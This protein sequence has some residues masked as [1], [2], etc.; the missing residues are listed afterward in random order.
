[1]GV[2][3]KRVSFDPAS[4]EDVKEAITKQDIRNLIREGIIRILPARGVSRARANKIK[5]QK[6]KGLK[7][8]LGSRKGTKGARSPSKRKWINQVRSQRAFLKRILERKIVT[9]DVYK[10]LYR[11]VGGGFFR[12][13]KHIQIFMD[14][15]SL[16]SKKDK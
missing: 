3:P 2:S 13:V 8:G 9:H 5:R 12:S 10:S 4:L 6:R 14:E 11:K 15:R 16:V 7:K 1:M